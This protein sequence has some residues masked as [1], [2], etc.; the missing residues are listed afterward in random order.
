MGKSQN[1]GATAS[2]ANTDVGNMDEL[3]GWLNKYMYGHMT[4]QISNGEQNEIKEELLMNKTESQDLDTTPILI[5]LEASLPTEV[6]TSMND[7]QE[8]QS[9]PDSDDG[10]VDPRDICTPNGFWYWEISL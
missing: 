2:T 9:N 10:E 8:P 3:D 7:K 5:P 1:Q 4:K 6:P